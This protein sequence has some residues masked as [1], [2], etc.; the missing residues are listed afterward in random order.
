MKLLADNSGFEIERITYDSRSW[1]FW[2]SEQYSKNIS[3]L[4]EKSYYV[5]PKKSIFT[6]EEIKK[7]E[8]ETVKLNEIGE[9]DQAEFYLR[10]IN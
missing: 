8:Q 7:F 5:N 2:G 4:D 3:L 9:G 1:Q 10:K 6:E